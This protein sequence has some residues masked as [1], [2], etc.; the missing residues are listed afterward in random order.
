[1]TRFSC[2]VLSI[3]TFI[4]GNSLP[5]LI[6][7]LWNILIHSFQPPFGCSVFG[8]SLQ[9]RTLRSYEDPNDYPTHSLGLETKPIGIFSVKVKPN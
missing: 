1:M 8:P 5:V 4:E 3:K 2:S 9:S 6:P 7:F